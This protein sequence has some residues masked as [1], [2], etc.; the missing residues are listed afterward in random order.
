M[1]PHSGAQPVLPFR[2][3]L[4]PHA[5]SFTDWQTPI[6]LRSSSE[7]KDFVRTLALQPGTYQ[8]CL[9]A[10][11]KTEKLLVHL[12][13]VMPF[14]LSKNILALCSTN[15]WWME[16]GSHLLLNP[17]L[18]MD[19]YSTVPV[20]IICSALIALLCTKRYCGHGRACSIISDWW[21]HLQTLNGR[22]LGAVARSS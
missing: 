13:V 5:G 4:L 21:P 7:T 6:T 15:L 9:H 3:C 11:R 22:L 17:S 8:V 12:T 10:C 1:G 20:S 19:R 18:E 14:F 2:H 16:S